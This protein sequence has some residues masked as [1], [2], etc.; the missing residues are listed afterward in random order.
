MDAKSAFLNGDLNEEVYV[1]QPDGFV[2]T[3][4]LDY[5]CKLKKA[6]YGLKQVPRAW[7]DGL[8]SY[9]QQQGFKKGYAD[10]NLYVKNEG[11][12]ILIIVVYVDDV[13]FGSD[14]VVLFPW[15]A[16]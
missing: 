7:C 12:N 14:K 11:N 2:L 3:N 13:I 4:D 6:L 8:D 5:V 9:L 15:V 10:S 1:E 16:N